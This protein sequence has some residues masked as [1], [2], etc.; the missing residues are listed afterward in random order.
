MASATQ[1]AADVVRHLEN[2]VQLIDLSTHD[3]RADVIS[4]YIFT[5]DGNTT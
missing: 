4:M 1:A 3:R 2:G 5:K